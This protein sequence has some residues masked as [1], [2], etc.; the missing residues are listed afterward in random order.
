MRHRTVQ[1]QTAPAHGLADG[2]RSSAST[3][4]KGRLYLIGDV[5]ALTSLSTHALRAWERVGLLAPRRSAGGVRQ[6]TE[7]DLARIRLIARTLAA[8][9]LSRRALAAL[10]RSGELRPD[11]TDYA[12]RPPSAHRSPTRTASAPGDDLSADQWQR[13]RRL[14]DAIARV[15]S[16]VASGRPLPD[17]LAI[18]CHETCHAFAVSDAILWLVDPPPG[19]PPAADRAVPAPALVAV[20]A[21]GPRSEHVLQ[22]AQPARITVDQ[23][24]SAAA[25]ALRTRRGVIVNAMDTSPLIHPELKA[26]LPG[27]AL[28]VVP[29]LTSDGDAVGALALRET[30]D[31]E[32]F[33]PKDL[34]RAQLFAT[35]AAIA[36]ETARLHDAI[37]VAREQAEA[38]R[39]RWRAAVD[40]MPQLVCTCDT[41]PRATYSNPALERFTGRP[42]DSTIPP[43]AWA[44]HFG[45]YL[46]DGSGAMPVD[47]M[48]F[49]RALRENAPAHEITILHR[50]PD[51]AERLAV[52]DAAPMRTPQGKLLGAVAVGRDVTL[53]RR[54]AQREQCLAAVMRAGLCAPNPA[55]FAGRAAGVVAALIAHAGVPV[56]V[57]S[58]HLIDPETGAFRCAAALGANQASAEGTT[59]LL[60]ARELGWHAFTTEMHCSPPDGA[61]PP[62]ADEALGRA[63]P[64]TGVRSWAALP[65]QSGG[66]AFGALTVGLGVPHV[67]DE[68]ERA[69]I[70]SCAAA[71]ALVVQNDQLFAAERRRS[72]ELQAVLEGVDA[73]ITLVAADGSIRLRN[74]AAAK[75]TRRP[76]YRGTLAENTA[77]YH[78]RDAATGAV[79]PADQT[80][81]AR[82]LRGKHARDVRLLMRDGHG[83]DRIMLSSSNPVRDGAGHVVA[84]VTIFRDVTAQTR[85]ARLFERLSQELGATLDPAREMQALADALVA[86]ADVDTAAVYET[87][88]DGASLRLLAT[89]NYPPIIQARVQSIPAAAHTIAA[90]ALRTGRP[91]VIHNWAEL[92]GPEHELTRQLAARLGSVSGAALPLLARGRVAGVLVVGAAHRNQFPPEEIA[93]LLDLA[94]RAGLALDNAHL[95]KA[96]HD[97]AAELSAIIEAMAEGVRV[98]DASGRITRVNRAGAAFLGVPREQALQSTEEYAAINYP[99]WSDGRPMAPEDR[100]LARALRGE[101]DTDFEMILRQADTQE[102]L[103]LRSSYAPIRDEATGAV[104]GAVAVGRDVTPLKALEQARAE[105]LSVVAHELKTPLTSLLGFLQAAQRKQA[106]SGHRP[107]PPGMDAVAALDWWN[108]MDR[109]LARIERQALRLERLVNDLL[110]STRVRQG[111]LEYCWATGDLA[112]AVAEAVEEQRIAH[113]DRHIELTTPDEPLLVRLDADRVG[114]VIANLISNALKYSRAEQTVAVAVDAQTDAASGTRAAVVRV[115][116]AG[117][118]IPVQHQPHL[119]EPFFRVPGVEVQSGSGIGLGIGLHVV[120]AIV[121]RHGGRIWVESAPGRGSTF[122]FTIPLVDGK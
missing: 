119:F 50:M 46:P 9:R 35:Q 76:K 87:A 117:P 52:W 116:D 74:A 22:G 11:A 2:G 24:R 94:G 12:T 40:D 91:Q 45:V 72:E 120:H 95:Y 113:P 37:R 108:D 70:E 53:E 43:E 100:P 44:A 25:L 64:I 61:P 85:R 5:A 56:V 81:V 32:R 33:G 13:E 92:V 7:D 84:A 23:P 38:E 39:A 67:W 96:A 73:G 88:P 99:R 21:F 34:E 80:P 66:A 31:P 110:D 26:L 97:T 59:A 49:V 29:L 14:L 78:L 121:T 36:I 19:A 102:D 42:P 8:R 82:A 90:H 75:L 83:R 114:Q 93:L 48:P 101:S 16:A 10:L 4:P 62:W 17:V 122:A 115:R 18:V 112:G 86:L 28:L 57:A 106:R 98:S 47:E 109:L 20:A 71:L 55:D 104:V 107:A 68:A 118:G 41:Q 51:G 111:R 6:Y 77:T 63:W 30:L 69:W 1:T 15:G 3:P 54:R 89:R 103:W 79:V 65:L 60:C 27:A 105:F 58:L